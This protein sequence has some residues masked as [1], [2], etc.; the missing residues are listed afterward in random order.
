MRFIGTI[1][2]ALEL[3]S[4]ALTLKQEC[5]EHNINYRSIKYRLTKLRYKIHNHIKRIG[6]K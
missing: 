2:L 4:L 6:N 1:I 3:I 5:K